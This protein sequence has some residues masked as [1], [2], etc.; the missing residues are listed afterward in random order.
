MGFLDES[1]REEELRKNWYANFR[2]GIQTSR[3]FYPECEVDCTANHLPPREYNALYGWAEIAISS[4]LC[5][6]GNQLPNG[7]C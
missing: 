3:W 5:M 7:L 2:P 6:S 4:A 1:E